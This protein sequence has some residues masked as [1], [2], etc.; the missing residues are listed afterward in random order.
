MLGNVIQL[1]LLFRRV[2]LGGMLRGRTISSLGDGQDVMSR[3]WFEMGHVVTPEIHQ[4]C[5]KPEMKDI[6]RCCV[7][8]VPFSI[9]S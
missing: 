1:K 4:T 5:W 9:T 2:C 3:P 8:V 7:V 6:L